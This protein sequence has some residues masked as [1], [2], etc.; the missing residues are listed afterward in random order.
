VSGLWAALAA[1]VK[2]IIEAFLGKPIEE[3]EE[4][5]DSDSDSDSDSVFSDDDW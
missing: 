3:S 1:L 5:R 4:F 2:G